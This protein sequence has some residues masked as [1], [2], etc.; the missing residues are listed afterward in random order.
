M[1]GTTLRPSIIVPEGANNEFRD[2]PGGPGSSFGGPRGGFLNNRRSGLPLRTLLRKPPLGPPKPLPG[3]PG[4][5]QDSLLA[6]P[7]TI[8]DRLRVPLFLLLLLLLLI[9]KSSVQLR[10]LQ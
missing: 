8:I 5:P 1:G 7:G 6:P 4:P 10:Y 3:P 2:G 9:R